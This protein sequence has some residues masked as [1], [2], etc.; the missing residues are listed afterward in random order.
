MR[1]AALALVGL[2]GCHREGPTGAAI[3]DGGTA[4]SDSSSMVDD[5]QSIV[6]TTVGSAPDVGTIDA[7]GLAAVAPTAGRSWTACGAGCEYLTVPLPGFQAA[8]RG[9]V[10]AATVDGEMYARWSTG[11]GSRRLVEVV[12]VKDGSTIAAA[13]QKASL[14]NCA[15]AGQAVGAPLVIP[16]LHTELGLIWSRVD[17]K[18]WTLGGWGKWLAVPGP[19]ATTFFAEAVGGSFR[20]NTVRAASASGSWTTLDTTPFPASLTVARGD[21]IFWPT[22]DGGGRA[23][24]RGR[25]S[26]T[27]G[28]ETFLAV[29]GASIHALALGDDKLAWIEGRGPR[30][31]EA[32]YLSV[33]LHWSKLP[34]RPADLLPAGSTP[35]PSKAGL[36]DLAIGSD[37]A[38][39]IGF[40]E[41]GKD[42]A[43][44]VTR[45]STKEVWRIPA[46]PGSALVTA[47]AV[48]ATHL[49]AAEAE[50]TKTGSIARL[51]RL[52]LANLPD[53]AKG[54]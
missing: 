53:L 6:D 29:S 14:S 40:D 31:V 38:A 28:T 25:T 7:C 36:V 5:G 21:A 3:Q 9:T 51:L 52:T 47:L 30:A 13:E 18:A 35:L 15:P 26:E 2:F 1:G 27:P 42:S 50:P 48:S 20:D 34:K 37:Y 41:T 46:R 4:I 24:L 11:D 49:I 22:V 19:L 32:I 45:L 44:I 43:L 33:D 8:G 12:R 17:P 16:F 10:S 23:V 39:T 54:G